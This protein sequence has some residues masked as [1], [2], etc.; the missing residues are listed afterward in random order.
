MQAGAID[1][2]EWFV[3]TSIIVYGAMRNKALANFR[4]DNALLK[5]TQAR[6]KADDLHV[7]RFAVKQFH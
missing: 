2:Q 6:S 1:E 3:W 5:H 7:P 4:P